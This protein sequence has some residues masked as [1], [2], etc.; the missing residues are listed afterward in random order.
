MTDPGFLDVDSRTLRLPPSRL[1]GADLAKLQS[2]IARH[3]RSTAGMPR[4][5]ICRG[6]MGN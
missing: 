2:Q 6:Q 3:V 5:L 4:L 1:A